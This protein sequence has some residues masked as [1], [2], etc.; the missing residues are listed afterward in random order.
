[1]IYTCP[2]TANLK[3][4]TLEIRECP[5]CG[6]EIEIASTDLKAKCRRC[7]FTI[8]N[9]ANSCIEYCQY[10]KECLGEELYNKL[11]KEARNE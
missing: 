4:P 1:M 10:A 2:G 9:D 11:K 5:N 3:T 6:Y 7:G 8:Y